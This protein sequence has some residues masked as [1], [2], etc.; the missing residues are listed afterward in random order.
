VY[1]YVYVY[2]HVYVYTH[3]IHARAYYLVPPA[4]CTQHLV[5]T[6]EE[7]EEEEVVVVVVVVAEECLRVSRCW[8]ITLTRRERVVNCTGAGVVG[9]WGDGGG[10]G[11][12]GSKERYLSSR[13]TTRYQFRFHL[14]GS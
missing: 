7:K 13:N 5:D 9:G 8:Y 6:R 10:G 11:G 12:G 1:I 3:R 2:V 4:M 14:T